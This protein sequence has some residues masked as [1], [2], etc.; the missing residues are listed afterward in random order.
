M[1]R[2]EPASA[3]PEKRF[4][5]KELTTDARTPAWDTG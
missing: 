5:H 3:L 2:M 1:I 4:F